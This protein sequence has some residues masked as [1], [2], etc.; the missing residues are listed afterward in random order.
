MRDLTPIFFA[1]CCIGILWSLYRA[2]KRPD[3]DF[4][5]LDLLMENGKVSKI[6]C[7]VMGSFGLHSWIMLDLETHGRMTEG[8]LTIYGA[9]WVS[10]LLIRLFT[11]QVKND[12]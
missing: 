3:V 12:A 9:T 4:N 7:L 8:Y 1:L 10:P 11:P 5:F 6:S 2:H